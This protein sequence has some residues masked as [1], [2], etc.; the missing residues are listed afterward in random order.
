MVASRIAVTMITRPKIE[1]KG[2]KARR[3]S[4]NIIWCLLVL[5]AC[6]SER[7]RSDRA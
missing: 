3:A 6:C 7:L 1:A 5:L 4:T 2:R